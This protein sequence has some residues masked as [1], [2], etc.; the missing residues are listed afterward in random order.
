MSE[1]DPFFAPRSV[2]L[3]GV[4]RDMDKFNGIVLKNLLAVN[5][6][7]RIYLV[8]PNA[9]EILGIKCYPRVVDLPEV[10]DLAII[11][12]P[13]VTPILE[14]CGKKGIKNVIIQVD[15]TL[16]GGA[17]QESID[18][19]INEVAA[20][21]GI[22]FMGPSLIG[23]INFPGH[24]TSSLIPVREHMARLGE[25][26]SRAGIGFMAQS[27]GL[28][29]AC[30]WWHPSQDISFAKVVH[31]HGQVNGS[32]SD[33]SLMRYIA[34]D[35]LVRVVSLFVRKISQSLVDAV[36]DCAPSKPILFKKCGQPLDVDKLEAAGALLVED[37]MDLFEIAKA[38]IFSPLPS[39]N[40]IGLIGPSSGAID[41]VLSEF[42]NNGLELAKPSP[43][44]ERKI[45]GLLGGRAAKRCNP[46][47]FWPPPRFFGHEIGRIHLEAVDYLMSDSNV[48]AIFLVLEFFH[49]IEFDLR[50]FKDLLA[51]HP[52]KPVMGVLIQAEEDGAKR[53]VRAATE[54]NI[55]I[56]SE[57]ERLVR[58]YA[59]LHK[60][61]R[62]RAKAAQS[63]PGGS[64]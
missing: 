16:Q 48:D 59:M 28:A 54:M 43:A 8:N 62:T 22:K 2:A 42:K 38:F 23:L 4:S 14:N 64:P 56:F 11:L 12:Y 10:P 13:D 1:I 57:P 30:G 6:P 35:P 46:V 34:S 61:S 37:Y 3:V 33:G 31:F 20:R 21:F 52:G 7:G 17:N 39:G 47:D 15:V 53:V 9:K 58:A 24:F 45:A 44:I 27:G 40:R 41:V 55:P 19:A 5:Y 18:E 36:R 26:P 49:E 51:N 32:I 50:I 29:G 63:K 25:D 60:Y